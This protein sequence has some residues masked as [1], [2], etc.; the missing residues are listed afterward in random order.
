MSGCSA[1][2]F[3]WDYNGDAAVGTPVPWSTGSLVFDLVEGVTVA[4][5]EGARGPG[6]SEA[7]LGVEAAR[8][9]GVAQR[10]QV[11]PGESIFTQAAQRLGHQRGGAAAA[12]AVGMALAK[13]GPDLVEGVLVPGQVLRIDGLEA[14]YGVSRTV[15]REVAKVLE[16]L[17]IVSSRRRVGVR[18]RPRRE[19]NL[20]DPRIIRWR[21]D[22][23]GHTEQLRLL[24]ELRHGIEP[25]AAQLAAR[26][27]TPEQ[28]GKLTGAVI[29]MTV[30]GMTGDLEAYLAHDVT[31]HQVLLEASGNEMFAALAPV[32]AEVLTGRTH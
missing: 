31:F 22:G 20:F 27:A 29:G 1:S 2:G 24:S 15:I 21:L 9:W 12:P 8:P 3:A 17:Q 16:S 32:A 26:H 4:E 5:V 7:A 6:L 23:P 14:R 10:P 18:V 28:C 19:W 13:I 25:V 11:Y 30:T